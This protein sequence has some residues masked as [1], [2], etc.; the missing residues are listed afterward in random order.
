MKKKYFIVLFFALW[1]GLSLYGQNFLGLQSSNYAGTY[2]LYTQPASIADNRLRFDINL[3]GMSTSLYTNYMGINSSALRSKVFQNQLSQG[4]AYPDPRNLYFPRHNNGNKNYAYVNNDIYMPLSFMVTL[5]PKHAIGFTWRNRTFVNADNI[6]Q[7]IGDLAYSERNDTA[8]LNKPFSIKG[9][10]IVAAMY[11]EFAGT[12]GRVVYDNGKHFVKVGGT[13][14][15]LQ[16]LSAANLYANNGMANVENDS[17]IDAIDW[18]MDYSAS[19][20]FDTRG[21]NQGAVTRDFLKG[22]FPSGWGMDLGAVYE[23]RP[24]YESFKY[25][26]NGE[27][28]VRRDKNK[29]KL[30]AGLSILDI[31]SVT[32][33]K[34]ANSGNFNGTTENLFIDP[35][36]YDNYNQVVDSLIIKN[37]SFDST[38]TKVRFALPTAICAQIDYNIWKNLYVNFMP[39]IAIKNYSNARRITTVS[40]FSITPRWEGRWAGIS[41]PLSVD[42]NKQLG[43]GMT[44][45]A[46]PFIIGTNYGGSALLQKDIR[47]FDVHAALRIPIHYRTKDDRDGDGIRDKKDICPDV[48]GIAQFKGCPDTDG[49]GIEDAKDVCPTAVGTA[50]MNGCPDTDGDGL[51]DN[52]DSCPTEAGTE[53]M[54][55][56]PDTDGDGITNNEDACP[57]D[58]GPVEMKGCPDTDKDG[59]PNNE[60]ACPNDAGIK[61]MNGCPDADRDGI[62]DKQDD[63]PTVAGT[64]EFKG[65]PDTDKDGISDANDACPKEPG[66]KPFKGCPDVDGDGIVDKD[67]KCPKEPGLLE[68]KGCPVVEN[69]DTDG[70]G[71][72]NLEDIC[73]TLAGIKQFKGCPDTDK[74]NVEDR[75]DL[76]PSVAGLPQFKGCPDTDKD[77]VE[78]KMDACPTEFGLARLNGCPVPDIDNDGI[79]DEMDKCPLTPGIVELEGCPKI[80]Q[81]KEVMLAFNNLE[82]ETAKAIILPSSFGDLDTL[83]TYL[84]AHPEYRLQITGHTDNQGDDAKNMDLSIRRAEAVKT[85]LVQ[86]GIDA[87]RFLTAG[88]GEIKPVAD[89]ETPEGRAKNRRVEL[90]IIPN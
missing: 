42:Q 2:G 82:F 58:A 10:R 23:Y 39:F 61:E 70:D 64:A 11:N 33:K 87:T 49:D 5:S 9:M 74:D 20:N 13:V 47:M 48:P 57:L 44:L 86:R 65:C 89:N 19:T 84:I 36:G 76:C 32:Y 17:I 31:G 75:Y 1:G 78:D 43:L 4:F 51:P 14:K 83:A 6:P 28:L 59:I 3:G 73:P 52:D 81:P 60:D 56:C 53:A 22:S 26:K 66:S 80:E 45:R 63:C 68:N 88:Y 46:G 38:S 8:Y 41:V 40:N 55:G 7:N 85:Y 18:D 37:F 16:G 24:K 30:R 35:G 15:L 54:H 27:T 90:V 72:P 25:Q 34:S 50:A 77:G 79:N 69:N 29:Y 71:I 21:A 12:Y 67:D 62:T